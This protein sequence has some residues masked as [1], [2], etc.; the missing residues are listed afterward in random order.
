MESQ[1]GEQEGNRCPWP[2]MPGGKQALRERE[3]VPSLL[4]EDGA[5]KSHIRQLCARTD[6]DPTEIGRSQ[7]QARYCFWHFFFY[8][9]E[10][11]QVVPVSKPPPLH[12]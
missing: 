6:S 4:P 9:L 3:G 1:R 12:K 2:E 10:L 7:F 11:L 8:H 5:S